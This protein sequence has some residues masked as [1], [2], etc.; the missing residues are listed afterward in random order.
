MH[1]E[2]NKE[3]W[4]RYIDV[5]LSARYFHTTQESRAL[6]DLRDEML[7]EVAALP[8][9]LLPHA[10]LSSLL[11]G[12]ITLAK[13][14]WSVRGPFPLEVVYNNGN[15]AIVSPG[16]V[17]EK[18]SDIPYICDFKSY[19]RCIGD[20][21]PLAAEL[22]ALIQKM[23][24]K[25]LIRCAT[26]RSRSV[27]FDPD[28][29][30][31]VN[32]MSAGSMANLQPDLIP[33]LTRDGVEHPEMAIELLNSPFA[34][35]PGAGTMLCWAD[36]EMVAAFPKHLRA[37]R[38]LA[39]VRIAENETPAGEGS[40]LWVERVLPVS[41][42]TAEMAA[43]AKAVKSIGDYKQIDYR[44]KYVLDGVRFALELENGT[45]CDAL[46][47]YALVAFANNDILHGQTWRPG[48]VL[49]RT[50]AKYL[51]QCGHAQLSSDRQKRAMEVVHHYF[52]S[53]LITTMLSGAMNSQHVPMDVR[54]VA[55]ISEKFLHPNKVL[56]LIDT[57]SS[58]FSAEAASEIRASV[59]RH[60]MDVIVRGV[61]REC[62]SPN[63]V[64]IMSKELG[65]K[66]TGVE[67]TCSPVNARHYGT[68]SFGKQGA[69][70]DPGTIMSLVESQSDDP[71]EAFDETLN[72]AKRILASATGAFIFN[73]VSTDL[74]D[75]VFWDECQKKRSA[76]LSL[77]DKAVYLAILQDRGIDRF[78]AYLK[79][80]KDWEL[81]EFAFGAQA[82]RPY[83]KNAPAKFRVRAAGAVL[84]L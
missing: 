80:D 42:F 48:Y 55:N 28:M 31:F 76:P 83:I 71:I 79:S 72:A 30:H 5:V 25:G 11:A 13:H 58:S 9:S 43:Q 41:D 67:V 50:T 59:P 24:V 69:R 12:D 26:N 46:D 35:F 37:Y 33:T 60:L 32:R 6:Y 64:R 73:G 4:K 47:Q 52:P 18:F 56:N 62:D 21:A 70:V 3:D 38:P 29:M 8:K 66:T 2:Q 17:V 23:K 19:W 63:H 53:G 68:S 77:P 84:S 20:N 49:C 39:E 57:E 36:P 51:A 61:L 65:V 81:A 82:L 78:A 15:P 34:G 74:D 75:Q 1:A 27:L 16:G 14:L 44:T 40:P 54:R 7:A 22:L 10:L 45:A